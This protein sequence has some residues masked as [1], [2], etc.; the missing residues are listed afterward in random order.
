[1]EV[2]VTFQHVTKND[3]Y[4]ALVRMGVEKGFVVIPEFR[5]HLDN[6][7]RKKNIDLVW[8]TRK[9]DMAA[10]QDR[11]SL[12][13]WTLHATFEI[14]SCDVRNIPRKEF[15]RHI[16]DLPTIQNTGAT[17]PITHFIA[18]YTSAH[19]RN[20]NPRR[21]VQADI[22]ERKGWA[23]GTSVSVLDGRDLAV[24]RAMPVAGNP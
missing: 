11:P 12:E 21:D 16:R 23:K 17:I 3:L 19:D 5:V 2:E 7:K 10:Y 9:S 20:W 14:E 22:S 15:D 13:Y 6:G 8:A 1:M 18:L 4:A 24:V